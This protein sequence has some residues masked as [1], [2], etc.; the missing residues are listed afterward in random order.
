MSKARREKTRGQ[1]IAEVALVLPVLLLVMMGILDFGRA[2][3]AYNSLSNAAR[4]GARVAIVDQTVTGGVSVGAR[5][6]ADQ[7]T[8]LGVNPSTDVDVTY[9]KPDGTACPAHS[10]GCVAEVTVRNRYRAIT[11]IIGNII[12]PINLAATT[13]LE[14]EFTKP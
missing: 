11:P 2:V 12:G 14:I 3:F 8:G 4:D 9:T 5:R 6:A 7:A 13:A 1:A 10:L